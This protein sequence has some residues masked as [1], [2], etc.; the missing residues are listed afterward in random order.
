MAIQVNRVLN[1]KPDPKLTLAPRLKASFWAKITAPKEA[2]NHPGTKIWPVE[3]QLTLGSCTAFGGKHLVEYLDLKD[4]NWIPR[5]A[6]FLYYN[7][8]LWNDTINEDSGAYITD[9][10]ESLKVYGLCHEGLWPYDVSRFTQKPPANAYDEADDYQAIE[11]QWVQ[12]DDLRAVLAAGN[13][14]CFGTYVFDNIW[15]VGSDGKLPDLLPSDRLAGGHCMVITGYRTESD[16]VWFHVLNQWGDWGENGFCW[17]REDYMKMWASDFLVLTRVENVTEDAPQPPA[18]SP[19]P[20]PTPQPDP[21]PTP[22]PQPVPPSP[23]RS[24]ALA[25]LWKRLGLMK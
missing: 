23:Q 19:S 25:G 17:I 18:P 15:R 3:D 11:W 12:F 8:R 20:T 9:I 10:L 13:I 5:S 16:G 22:S 21:A 7:N 4:G 1:W 6:L 2:E 14:V 24:C